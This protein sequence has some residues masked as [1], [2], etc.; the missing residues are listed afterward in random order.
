M[1]LN[2]DKL[3][4]SFYFIEWTETKIVSVIAI[5]NDKNKV[6]FMGDSKEDTIGQLVD[7]VKEGKIKL[8]S[9]IDLP[10]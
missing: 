3:Q 7:Y 5:F 4:D 6:L 1:E 10:K 9:K 8:I 2:I